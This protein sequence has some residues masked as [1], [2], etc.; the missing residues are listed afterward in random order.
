MLVL[1]K[2]VE[3]IS[4]GNIRQHLA[5]KAMFLGDRINP[6]IRKFPLC[7]SIRAVAAITIND[8]HG[9]HHKP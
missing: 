5:N 9:F 7:N 2:S 6:Q 1:D 4:E 3:L 8:L